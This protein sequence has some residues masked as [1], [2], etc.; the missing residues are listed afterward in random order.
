[1]IISWICEF[2]LMIYQELFEN[3]TITYESDQEND[4]VYMRCDLQMHI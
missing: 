4:E 1:M 3:C 2:L